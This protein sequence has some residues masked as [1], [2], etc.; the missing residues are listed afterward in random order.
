MPL[1]TVVQTYSRAN[2]LE[3]EQ[4]E[5]ISWKKHVQLTAS[6]TYIA[7]QAVAESVATPGTFNAYNAAGTDGEASPTAIL[8]VNCST[9]SSGNITVGQNADPSGRTAKSIEVYFGGVFDTSKLFKDNASTALDATAAGKLGK[10]VKG[11]LT[12]GLLKLN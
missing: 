5:A 4:P 1:D 7:G 11:T 12:A 2:Y 10:L 6:K 8:P 3:P 9:D